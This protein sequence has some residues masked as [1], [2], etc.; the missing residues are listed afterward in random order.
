MHRRLLGRVLVASAGVVVLAG[1]LL[2]PS[3]AGNTSSIT[4]GW[5]IVP[6]DAWAVGSR[7][8][9]GDFMGPTSR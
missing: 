2:A 7:A 5:R 8:P 9:G 4:A 3:G 6:S 1:L